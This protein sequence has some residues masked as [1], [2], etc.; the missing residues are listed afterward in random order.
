MGDS[1]C[2]LGRGRNPERQP[3]GNLVSQRQGPAGSPGEGESLAR[4]G[5]CDWDG[6]GRLETPLVQPE[7]GRVAGGDLYD[8]ERR[9]EA[10]ESRKTD[11]SPR[12]Q[13][14]SVYQNVRHWRDERRPCQSGRDSEERVR[15]K[16]LGHS[17]QASLCWTRGP[18]D[19]GGCGYANGVPSG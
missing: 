7:E 9:R 13:P 19:A 8:K 10:E 11:A 14:S 3:G 18:G 15:D 17:G 5:G 6:G 4:E 2:R 1:G 16:A 12:L